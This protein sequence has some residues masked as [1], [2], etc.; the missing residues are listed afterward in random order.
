MQEENLEIL[1]KKNFSGMEAD[2]HIMRGG[3]ERLR[4]ELPERVRVRES[5]QRGCRGGVL[6]QISKNP[7][8]GDGINRAKRKGGLCSFGKKKTSARI[9][10]PMPN[11]GRDAF[12]KLTGKALPTLHTRGEVGKMASNERP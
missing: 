1:K 4:R 7:E 10:R 2:F 5:F 3:K 8:V 9:R 6:K 12:G 11:G